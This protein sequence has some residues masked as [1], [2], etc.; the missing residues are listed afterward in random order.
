MMRMMTLTLTILAA[1]K[2]RD[3]GRNMRG[4]FD[5]IQWLSFLSQQ[6]VPICCLG[7]HDS[8]TLKVQ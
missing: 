8:C 6:F 2:C 4:F 3:F 1:P 7:C 5:F